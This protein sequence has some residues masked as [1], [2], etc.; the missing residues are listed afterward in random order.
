M[1]ILP[2][3]VDEEFGCLVICNSIWIPKCVVYVVRNGASVRVN[4][5]IALLYALLSNLG[6]FNYILSIGKTE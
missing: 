5:P 3:D 6:H 1:Y 2:C 4:I